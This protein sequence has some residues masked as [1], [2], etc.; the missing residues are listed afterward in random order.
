[1]TSIVAKE[2]VWVGLCLRLHRDW[3]DRRVSSASNYR[4]PRLR[5]LVAWQ[6]EVEHDRSDEEPWQMG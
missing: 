6:G 5:W 1:M 4:A 2:G 3:A